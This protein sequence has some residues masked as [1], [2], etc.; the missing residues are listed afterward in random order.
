MLEYNL[1]VNMF[2]NPVQIIYTIFSDISMIQTQQNIKKNMPAFIKVL[3]GGWCQILL[4]S[5]Y[6]YF[7]F[8]DSILCNLRNGLRRRQS[9]NG[10]W[11]HHMLQWQQQR[12]SREGYCCLLDEMKSML[13]VAIGTIYCMH[14]AYTTYTHIYIS[15]TRKRCGR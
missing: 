7:R 14:V 10:H 6:I 12:D 9:N 15:I 5:I 8:V 4:I 3:Y 2:I 13:F 1:M 11:L